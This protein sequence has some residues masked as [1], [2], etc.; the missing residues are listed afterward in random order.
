MLCCVLSRFSRVRLFAAP[1]DCSPP[2]SSDHGL[3]Q[4]RIL[5]LPC[6]LPGD[7]SSLPRDQTRISCNAGRFF[8]PLSH[9]GSPILIVT[10]VFFLFYLLVMAALT[11][12]GKSG[13]RMECMRRLQGIHQGKGKE[14][15]W[16][17]QKGHKVKSLSC[18]QL[19]QTP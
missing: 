17:V 5:E 19:F 9:L 15:T 11:H 16:K 8:Y 14:K 12:E 10:C 1:K 2:G 13:S 18:V 4:T 7:G 6:S 3:L